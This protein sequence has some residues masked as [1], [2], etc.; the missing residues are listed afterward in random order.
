[1]I[2]KIQIMREKERV[3]IAITKIKQ[4]RIIRYNTR[5][6]L[7]E[8]PEARNDPNMKQPTR[9]Y[10]ELYM[11]ELELAFMG[12]IL[13]NQ[14]TTLRNKDLVFKNQKA[15]AMS[16]HRMERT[17]SRRNKHQRGARGSRTIYIDDITA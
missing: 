4:R 14:M 17:M 5:R 11:E 10:D 15:L 1:M 2:M 16:I 3:V 12:A 7:E 6:I 13:R 9:D 8:M